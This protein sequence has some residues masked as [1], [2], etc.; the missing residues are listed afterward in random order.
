LTSLVGS[1]LS[2][3]EKEMD[4]VFGL[5]PGPQPKIGKVLLAYHLQKSCFSSIDAPTESIDPDQL[6][7]GILAVAYKHRLKKIPLTSE[8]AVPFFLLL[9][10]EI[11]LWGIPTG[12]G[13][14]LLDRVKLS[15]VHFSGG[16]REVEDR[17][18]FSLDFTQKV[19]PKYFQAKDFFEARESILK[20]MVIE[21]PSF[22][23]IDIDYFFGLHEHKTFKLPKRNIGAAAVDCMFYLVEDNRK[24]L[25]PLVIEAMETNNF[26]IFQDK[27]TPLYPLDS[28]ELRSLA[29]VLETNCNSKKTASLDTATFIL[30]DAIRNSK[31]IPL[32]VLDTLIKFIKNKTSRNKRESLPQ[33]YNALLERQEFSANAYILDFLIGDLENEVL[34]TEDAWWLAVKMRYNMNRK[35]I[36]RLRDAIK[37]KLAILGKAGN[38]LLEV[39]NSV[40]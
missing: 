40:C 2:T 7:K 4:D 16:S 21:I 26:K 24:R 12:S 11:A 34:K 39:M 25:E 8:N 31:N 10:E 36:L 9:A 6:R 13:S 27:V 32:E 14:P 17:L 23:F 35:Q 29:D 22:P 38:D 19:F 28:N 33:A 3:A 15:G 20:K 30:S 5:E 18:G 1:S 37:E